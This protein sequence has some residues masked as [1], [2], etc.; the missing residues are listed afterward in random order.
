MDRPLFKK[1]LLSLIL[2]LVPGIACA[3]ATVDVYKVE[4]SNDE[5]DLD[6]IY[7]QEDS[8]VG[9]S[10]RYDKDSD[11]TIEGWKVYI[12]SETSGTLFDSGDFSNGTAELNFTTEDIAAKSTGSISGVTLGQSANYTYT[13][14]VSLEYTTDSTTTDD[15]DGDDDEDDEVNDE[16]TQSLT[17]RVDMDPPDK[18]VLLD[19]PV[20]GEKSITVSWE[21]EILSQTGEVEKN[22][23]VQ[24]C[25]TA[26]DTTDETE[27]SVESLTKADGDDDASD[28]EDETEVAE[29]GDDDTV[30]EDDEAEEVV[31]GDDEPADGDDVV[32]DGDDNVVDGDDD[33]AEEDTET[34]EDGDTT[35]EDST[36]GDTDYVTSDISFEGCLTPIPETTADGSYRITD[37]NNGITYEIRAVAID[38]AG[39]MG[40]EWSDAIT[41]TPQEVD[42]FWEA[43][44][45][46]GGKE[47]GGFCFIATAAYG[48]YSHED[49]QLLR[50][51]RDRILM[52]SSLGRKII[53]T[54]YKVS[55][56][57]A[58]MVAESSVFSF[59]IKVVLYPIVLILG[60]MFN[61]SVLS[62][63]GII[64]LLLS[65]AFM[66]LYSMRR[67]RHQE[68]S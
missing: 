7:V 52:K 57:L 18:V 58:K 33:I 28:V 6:E 1:L 17:I 30:D 38:A 15:E 47:D 49:V 61:M 43:Y 22:V 27:S 20:P 34:I 64:A 21:P 10:I 50:T 60:F 48:S 39:N 59:V 63:I 68:V 42:D 23:T 66:L 62:Q 8:T 14:T 11:T 2:L 44:K 37:L 46:N 36:D 5:V 4:V 32:V 25:V 35:E 12:G 9:L 41:G 13:I 26:L 29:D 3:A 40:L 53:T 65:G 31:D 54:Y 51:F 67:H 56:P 55:P 45:N 16:P 19:E 24:F